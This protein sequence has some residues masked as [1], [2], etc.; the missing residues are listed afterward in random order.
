VVSK[1]GG[2][3]FFHG[4]KHAFGFPKM[5][6]ENFVDFIGDISGARLLF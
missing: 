3:G 4:A 5:F 2:I 6:T 1:V